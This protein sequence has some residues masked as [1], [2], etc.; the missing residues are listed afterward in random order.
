MLCGGTGCISNKSFKV[1][2]ALQAEIKKRNLEEKTSVVITGCNAFCAKGP[3]IIVMPDGIFYHSVTEEIVPELVDE[4]LIKGK[5]FEKLMYVSEKTNTTIPKIKDIPFFARQTIVSL[6]NRGIIDPENIDDYIAINGYRAL[7]KALSKM[8][9]AEIIDEIKKSGLR[10]RGGAGFPAGLKWEMCR[11]ARGN[12]KYVVCNADEGDP[13]AY[14]DRSIIELDPHSVLEG[15][16]IAALAVGANEGYIYI[17]TEYPLARQRLETAIKQAREYGI[18]GKNIFGTD[19]YCDIFIRQGSGAFVC[20]EAT[21]LVASIEG[22]YP[23]PR[24]KPP[25]LVDSGLWGKPTSLNN[26]ETFATVPSI[27]NNGA[28][29]FNK[30]GT[31]KSKGTKVFSLVGKIQNSGLVEVPMGITLKEII[32]DIG[33]GI[34]KGKKFKAVQTGGPSGGCIPE[35]LLDLPVDYERLAGAGSIMGSGGMIVMDEDTCMVDVARYYI[36]FTN[37]ESC[38]RCSSCR[39]GSSAILEI[40]ERICKGEGSEDDLVF[41]EELSAVI[42]DASMCGLGQSLPNPV[43]T[44][45]RYFKDEYEAHIKEKKCPAKVCKTLIRYHIDEKKCTGCMLCAKNC[46]SGAISGEAKKI[47]KIDLDKCVKCGL[48]MELCRFKAVV[49][50]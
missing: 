5:P 44:T 18:L 45:L 37:D 17:R 29:W 33:G 1:R 4:H 50:E 26:V 30:I 13:G 16:L 48:C 3:I 28:E 31:E 23:E 39:D 38:G 49:V 27:I 25:H 47:H 32:F 35:S 24:H 7:A 9:P 20:G 10:G 21:A 8:T 42:K 34:P 15:M 46:A 6:K 12:I 40:L 14:M 19:F 2:D 36:E 41:L 11:N 43:L 22:K